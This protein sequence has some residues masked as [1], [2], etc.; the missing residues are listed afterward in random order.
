[1]KGWDGGQAW[2]NS[3]TL[4]ARHNLAA[5]LVGG[6]DGSFRN[7]ILL[8]KFIKKMVSGDIIQQTDFLLKLFV[9]GDVSPQARARLLNYATR[10]SRELETQEET[11]RDITHTI[12][13]M[14]E[15]QLA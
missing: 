12:L 9:S 5:R 7:P 13:L 4:L 8:A 15:Y 2:L 3:A 14:P 1:M 6:H 10:P 11:L